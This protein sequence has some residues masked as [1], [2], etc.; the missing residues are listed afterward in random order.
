MIGQGVRRQRP[1][2]SRTESLPA[3]ALATAE[4]PVSRFPTHVVDLVAL[5]QTVAHP[6]QW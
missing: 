2:G 4:R 3:F 1:V 6:I 5:L